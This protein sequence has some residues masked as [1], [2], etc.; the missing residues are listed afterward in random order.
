MH[1]RNKIRTAAKELLINNTIALTRVFPTRVI[2]WATIELPA[3]AVYT[4]TEETRNDSSETAPRELIRDLMLVVEA[5]ISAG[6]TITPLLDDALDNIAKEI[7][8]VLAADFTLKDTCAD[9]FIGST[10]V[11]IIENGDELIGVITLKFKVEYSTYYPETVSGLD[12]FTT[13]QVKYKV[14][15]TL[16]DADLAQDFLEN[17]HE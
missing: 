1:Q 14:S 2:P 4:L 16:P 12:D 17:I 15:D 6:S 3:I 8:D 7:E 5:A 11:E 10:E 13:A 9:C